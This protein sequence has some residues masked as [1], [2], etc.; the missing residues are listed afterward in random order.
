[1]H[2]GTFNIG[3]LHTKLLEWFKS[4]KQRV[5]RRTGKCSLADISAYTLVKVNGIFC[6]HTDKSVVIAR[7]RLHE[8]AFLPEFFL[9]VGTLIQ[10]VKTNTVTKTSIYTRSIL[11]KKHTI[12]YNS[13]IDKNK[14]WKRYSRNCKETKHQQNLNSNTAE[15]GKVVLV[16]DK[17]E[18]KYKQSCCSQTK[19]RKRLHMQ[20]FIPC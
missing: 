2:K 8:A 6:E 12:Y 19:T 11:V 5:Q 9:H 13:K 7:W 17:Q 14:I 4:W 16:Q 10:R 15:T 3:W 1:M 20:R 18:E